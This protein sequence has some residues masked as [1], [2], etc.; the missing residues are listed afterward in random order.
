MKRVRHLGP[1]GRHFVLGGLGLL[2]FLLLFL[3]RRRFNRGLLLRP[4][5]PC[6]HQ[7]RPLRGGTGLGRHRGCWCNW[8]P[9][10]R[11]DLVPLK[12]GPTLGEGSMSSDQ[13]FHTGCVTPHPFL[14]HNRSTPGTQ[15]FHIGRQ[16]VPHHP[17]FPGMGDTTSVN[18]SPHTHPGISKEDSRSGYRKVQ[19]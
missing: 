15:N 13:R 2:L 1:D 8:I 7:S 5:R 4:P 12:V 10:L 6:G 9:Q 16:T 11:R 17:P 14:T 19:S 18:Y 3:L